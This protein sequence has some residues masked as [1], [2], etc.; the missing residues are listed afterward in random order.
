[1]PH[2]GPA[3]RGSVPHRPGGVWELAG[4][5]ALLAAWHLAFR[6]LGI[7][8]LRPRPVLLYLAGLLALWFVLAGIHPVFFSLLLVLYPQIYRHL[9]LPWPS[10]RRSP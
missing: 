7:D 4:L 6:R 8:Q 10:R 5:T 9:R 1:V 3:G 2:N